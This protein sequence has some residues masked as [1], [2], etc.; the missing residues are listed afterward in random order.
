MWDFI[1]NIFSGKKRDLTI[2]VLDEEDPGQAETFSFGSSDL[3]KFA[4]LII[5]V[6]ILLTSVIFLITPLGSMYS[7]Y[8]ETQLR[9]EILA[10]TEQVLALQDSLD[11]RDSQLHDLKNILIET[12]DTTFPAS[13]LDRGVLQTERMPDIPTRSI[14]FSPD[15]EMLTRNEL[16][17]SEFSGRS[18]EFPTHF[19]VNGSVTR[20]FNPEEGHPGIDI[21]ASDQS[22]FT[23]LAGGTV[24]KAGW[25]LEFGYVT[26][27]QH[28]D[29]YISVYKHGAKLYVKEGDIVQS[30]DLL[31]VVG[32]RG[33]LSFGSHLHLEIW[34]HG[35]AQDPLLY[36]IN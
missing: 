24:I 33:A 26:Y 8:Q 15:F 36:L 6:A 31:G 3:I 28:A 35:V 30:G 16:L 9:N 25:T 1:R 18:P 29:G 7:Q 21:A 19:P 5:V 13:Q 27:L 34:K 32:D 10:V 22:E 14:D 17:H 23:A 4:S 20:G 12:P 11:A 2:L